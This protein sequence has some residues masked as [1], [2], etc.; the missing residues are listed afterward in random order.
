M[1]K[2][3][4]S[5]PHL[6]RAPGP[7]HEACIRPVS[8]A[9]GKMTL[10]LAQCQ[11][12]CSAP[13]M[14]QQSCWASGRWAAQTHA[15]PTIPCLQPGLLAPT[16][17]SWCGQPKAWSP[18]GPSGVC[19]CHLLAEI[20]SRLCLTDKHLCFASNL[21]RQQARGQRALIEFF[22]VILIGSLLCDSYFFP[23]LSFPLLCKALC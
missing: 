13:L 3:G 15:C 8:F 18:V 17:A 11:W 12:C 22:N 2:W 1:V 20:I 19:E 5:S 23:S 14:I 9:V 6:P 4:W 21:R 10:A 16:A 7:S